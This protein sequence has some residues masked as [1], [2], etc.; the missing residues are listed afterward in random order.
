MLP[1]NLATPGNPKISANNRTEWTLSFPYK[2]I[3]TA[4]QG[5]AGGTACH[6]YN[7]KLCMKYWQNTQIFELANAKTSLAAEINTSV[8]KNE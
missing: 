5:H 8:I 4:R 7:L 3:P 2:T 6:C 1:T